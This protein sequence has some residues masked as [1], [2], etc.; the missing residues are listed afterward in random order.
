[1]GHET[2]V[3]GRILIAESGNGRSEVH[4]TGNH[5]TGRLREHTIVKHLVLAVL[6]H[7]HVDMKA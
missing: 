7:T 2:E 4:H 5:T 6:H 3:A 1:M